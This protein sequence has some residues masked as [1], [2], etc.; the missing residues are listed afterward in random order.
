[1]TALNANS[2]VMVTLRQATSIR[3]RHA[4]KRLGTATML[5]I[6]M[7]VGFKYSS[8]KLYPRDRRQFVTQDEFALATSQ[9]R[10][11]LVRLNSALPPSNTRRSPAS[12]SIFMISGTGNLSAS[13]SSV[14]VTTGCRFLTPPVW[15]VPNPL[16]KFVARPRCAML[17]SP[18][19]KVSVAAAHKTC[20]LVIAEAE[21]LSKAANQGS[22]STAKTV[23]AL[24][25]AANENS[26]T[27]AP[28]SHATQSRDESPHRIH[29]MTVICSF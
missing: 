1:M 11:G 28:T 18:R 9:T 20:T 16:M 13:Q 21:R 29:Q 22:G 17:S 23:L 6:A 3:R 14:T 24:A 7:D 2:L 4:Y 19:S 15:L 26:P 27:F 10:C 5:S 8:R 12:T 25:A